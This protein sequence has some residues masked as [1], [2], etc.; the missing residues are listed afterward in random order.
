MFVFINLLSDETM[1]ALLN[2]L[3][4][5]NYTHTTSS[6]VKHRKKI[7]IL[8]IYHCRSFIMITSSLKCL[9]S[10][11]VVSPQPLCSFISFSFLFS[12]YTPLSSSNLLS[13]YTPLSSSNLLSLDNSKK[14]TSHTQ[15]SRSKLVVY[16][17]INN[18]KV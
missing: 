8:F 17:A 4:D 14:S 5:S 6:F 11:I 15:S 12:S 10:F 2:K 18:T 7:N 16:F 13:S 1:P 3:K 9:F